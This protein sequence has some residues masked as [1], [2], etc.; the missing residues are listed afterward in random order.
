MGPFCGPAPPEPEKEQPRGSKSQEILGKAWDFHS[1]Q[2][3]EGISV[4]A[5]SS[6]AG[7]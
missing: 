4:L 2:K 7:P 6:L 3:L 5:Y 1:S